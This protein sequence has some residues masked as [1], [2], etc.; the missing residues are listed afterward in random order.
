MRTSGRLLFLMMSLM[1]VGGSG[2]SAD[3][4]VRH[5]VHQI[6]ISGTVTKD[7]VAADLDP[8]VHMISDVPPEQ[9]SKTGTYCFEFM[10]QNNQELA[11]QCFELSFY[12][13]SEGFPIS[14]DAFTYPLLFPEGTQ[15]I[16]LTM[17]GKQLGRI[18]GGSHPPVVHLLRPVAGEHWA[19]G[20]AQTVE[21]AASDLDG[22]ALTYSLSYSADGGKGYIPFG[23][24][25]TELISEIPAVLTELIPGSKHA[26]IRVQATD[27]IHFAEDV[28]GIFS[29]EQSENYPGN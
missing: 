8:V 19:A 11:R 17:L 20:Q 24:D 13:A 2:E 1:M 18:S 15:T 3:D 21:W 9:L 23:S 29:V 25:L 14:E 10:G 12:A 5:K 6:L 28:S 4:G 7:P 27:G 26:V 16:T 22:D